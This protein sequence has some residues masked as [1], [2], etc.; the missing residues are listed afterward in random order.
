MLKCE[1]DLKIYKY[2]FCF[3]YDVCVN[4]LEGINIKKLKRSKNKNF[5]QIDFQFACTLLS[6]GK[7]AMHMLK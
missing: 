5:S 4:Y 3:H 6:M 7:K 2:L 1:H